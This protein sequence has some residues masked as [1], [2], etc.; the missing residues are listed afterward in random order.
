MMR[1]VT[2]VQAVGAFLVGLLVTAARGGA[3]TGPRLGS[4]AA[5][6]ASVYLSYGAGMA[7]NDVADGDLDS[8]HDKK[9]DRAVASGAVP[10]AAGWTYCALL[11]SASLALARLAE[12]LI[13]GPIN[14]GPRFVRWTAANTSIMAA[15]ALGLQRVFLAKN[16]VCG[17]LACS[18]LIG[19]L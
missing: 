10:T 2:I 5:A 8:R 17:Y 11:S 1:P 15:Y 16:L 9:R 14:G 13:G 19:A 4:A 7:M 3:D 6:C 18:P 12:L